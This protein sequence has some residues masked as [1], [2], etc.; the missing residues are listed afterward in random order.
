MCLCLRIY[1]RFA[2]SIIAISIQCIHSFISGYLIVI[3]FI[4]MYGMVWYGAASLFLVPIFIRMKKGR[5]AMLRRKNCQNSRFFLFRIR[6][7]MFVSVS[8]SVLILLC[9]LCFVVFFCS[10]SAQKVHI[11]GYNMNDTLLLLLLN[12]SEGKRVRRVR[13]FL[14][15]YCI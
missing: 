4:F 6:I 3:I 11:C 10:P 8:V 13:I 5:R 2:F 1:I 9:V 14:Q 12:E 7:R 15:L